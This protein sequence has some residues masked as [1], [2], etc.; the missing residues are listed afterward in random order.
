MTGVYTAI[1][2]HSLVCTATSVRC[3]SALEGGLTRV[4]SSL[5]AC[6]VPNISVKRDLLQCQKRPV[7]PNVRDCLPPLHRFPSNSLVL[8]LSLSHTLTLAHSSRQPPSLSL[9]RVLSLS[10]RDI[11]VHTH[12][13]I[14]TERARERESE[15][16]RE[17]PPATGKYFAWCS[18]TWAT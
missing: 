9:A 16:E 7:R 8:S 17:R 2:T 14:R 12:T 13:Y 15:G 5:F 6:R 10:A 1:S 4:L 11:Y 18:P 3:S